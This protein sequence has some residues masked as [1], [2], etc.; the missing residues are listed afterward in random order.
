MQKSKSAFI[1][2]STDA[3]NKAEAVSKHLEGIKISSFVF[4][5]NLKKWRDSLIDYYDVYED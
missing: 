5:K 4:E 3:S 2:Y 1:S